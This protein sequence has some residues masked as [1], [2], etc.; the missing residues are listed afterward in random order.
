M[1]ITDI[2][3]WRAEIEL[4]TEFRDKN[5]GEFTETSRT[6]AGENIEYF[7]KGYSTGY[8]DSQDD[9]TTTLN[10]FHVICKLLIPTLWFQNP[11]ITAIP[12][13]SVDE[14]STP[15]AR[16]I[17]NHFYQ[18]CEVDDENELTVWDGYVLN[19]G[20]SKVGYTT[21]FGMDVPD[22]TKKKKKSLV[23]KALVAVGLKK[24]EESEVIRPEMSQKIIAEKPYI[25]WVSPF[26]FLYDPRARNL[27]E[28]MWCGEEFDKTVASLK[29]NPQYKNTSKL[30][31][32]RPDVP[33]DSNAK[34]PES[35]IEEFSIVK[36]YEI[37]YENKNKKYRLVIVKDG[38][39]YQEIYH[40]ESIY[41]IDGWQ[42]DIIE[43]N[44]H[45]HLQFKRSDLDKI[46]NLQDRFTAVIDNI[47]EQ[48]ER[49]STKILMR[50]GGLTPGGEKALKEGDVG[51]IVTTTDDV[52]QVVK[53]LALTQFK[54]DLKAII[55]ELINLITIMTGITKTKLL[56][57]SMGETA[58]GENIAHG[59]E[60]IRISD[61]KKDVDKFASKQVRKF[62]QVIQQFVEMDELELITGE[63]GIDPKT[64]AP[65]YNWL[66]AITG[67]MSEKLSTGEYSFRLEV[68]SSQKMDSALLNKRIENLMGI[69]ARTDIIALMQKQGKKVD[70]AEI[71][72]MW[73]Q[74]NPEIVRD[75]G[76]IIQ[77]VNQQ[78]QGLVPADDMLLGGRGGQTN[79]STVN[80]QRAQAAE[81]P[82]NPQQLMQE[83][84][85][86]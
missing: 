20:V 51:A 76:K 68:G 28:A 38:E 5:L 30:K 70:L 4:A 82:V 45:G 2:A 58:T 57:V 40:K 86:L 22:E 53:E 85:Q 26:K 59:G 49:F 24:K 14:E 23:D 61:M 16:A 84:G 65:K 48:L 12:K 3:R 64:G 25:K 75:P 81:A 62:W 10:F 33:E 17:L 7:E 47:L 54:G 60:T 11:Q 74:N 78:T 44:K 55:E 42:Y 18:D 32:Q 52:D 29:G 39:V 80:A 8:D 13:R 66:P 6:K 69:L 1:K 77:D 63:S 37:Q 56:G 36:L 35:Q 9:T 71:L 67:E 31:G 73:L 34:I 21:K 83:S 79:G 72:R 41:E 50:E 15:Y 46:K 43:F 27:D 19:R